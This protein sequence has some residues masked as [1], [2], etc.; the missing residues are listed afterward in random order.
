MLYRRRREHGLVGPDRLPWGHCKALDTPNLP[1]SHLSVT[2]LDV[3]TMQTLYGACLQGSY[4]QIQRPGF[5]Y[6]INAKKLLKVPVLNL[7]IS[8]E[9]MIRFITD[10]NTQS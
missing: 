9:W 6:L 1:E 8:G 10:V 4:S 5:I 2:S 7:S 3:E